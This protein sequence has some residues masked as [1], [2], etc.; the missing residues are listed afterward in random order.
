VIASNRMGGKNLTAYCDDTGEAVVS[1]DFPGSVLKI[2]SACCHSEPFG[3]A[4]GGLR[5]ESRS[6]NKGLA[7]FLL[8]CMQNRLRL[9]E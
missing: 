7:R 3:C 1:G 9:L 6:A 4:Q 2:N 5:E 8:R